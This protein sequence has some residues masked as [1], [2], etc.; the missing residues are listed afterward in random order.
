MDGGKTEMSYLILGL[1]LFLGVHLVRI[2]ADGWRTQIRAR[3]GQGAYKGIYSLFSLVGFGLII[4]GFGV[5]REHP[6]MLWTPPV[7]MRH[8]A[9]LLTLI[10]FILLAAAYVP[11][12][13]IK[14]R[15]HHP[16]VLSVKTWALAHLLSNGSVAHVVLFG[17]FLV[18]AV[19]NFVAARRRDRVEGTQYAAGTA[20]GTGMTVIVGAGAWAAFAFWLHGL[21]I[22]IRPF[23]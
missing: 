9:S 18:W 7:G 8:A 3:V 23:G 10:A 16:M 2:V 11:G 12:N 5:A 15:F 20:I 4:W 19:F 17:S 6:V 1:A 21:L 22:G 14:A 13:T